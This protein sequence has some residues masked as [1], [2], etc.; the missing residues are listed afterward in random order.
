MELYL[1]LSEAHSEEY[2]AACIPSISA[3]LL[4]R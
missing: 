3:V 1:V 4:L 2:N